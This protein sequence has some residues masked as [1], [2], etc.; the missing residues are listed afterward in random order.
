MKRYT[1]MAGL[2]LVFALLAAPAAA[3]SMNSLDIAVKGNGDAEVTADYTL[4]WLERIGIFMRIAKPE[5][6]LTQ[7]L[8]QYSGKD[9]TVTSVTP[10]KTVLSVADFAV[11]RQTGARPT[12]I[13]PTLD[14]SGVGEAVKGYRFS[15]FVSVDASPGVTVVSFPDGHQ[16]VFYE[17]LVIPSITYTEGSSPGCC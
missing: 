3:F 2:V 9:V 13:T 12:Y 10:G 4:T 16:Q 14:F 6:L 5:A 7:T 11:V 15:P 17:T 1:T 8:E